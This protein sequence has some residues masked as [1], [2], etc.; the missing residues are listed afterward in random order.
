MNADLSDQ[1][2]ECLWFTCLTFTY[3]VSCSV[4]LTL[5]FALTRSWYVLVLVLGAGSQ[6]SSSQSSIWWRYTCVN[7]ESKFSQTSVYNPHISLCHSAPRSTVNVLAN[8]R[9]FCHCCHETM[10]LYNWPVWTQNGF[11][12]RGNS[13]SLSATS[14]LCHFCS[15]SHFFPASFAEF[16]WGT[17]S[18]WVKVPDVFIHVCHPC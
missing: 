14:P 8:Q 18:Q 16:E 7:Q 3:S 10:L 5:V 15:A 4:G 9:A 17:D 13:Q 6:S 11:L 2:Q 12:T 1:L